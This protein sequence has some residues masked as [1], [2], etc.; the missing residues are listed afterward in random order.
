MGIHDIPGEN[1]GFKIIGATFVN[2]N[3]AVVLGE[4]K[5]P[6]ASRFVTWIWSKQGGFYWG[7]YHD[8]RSVAYKDYFARISDSVGK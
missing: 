1:V 8:S 5:S 3:E 4:V 7:H 6:T 2:E